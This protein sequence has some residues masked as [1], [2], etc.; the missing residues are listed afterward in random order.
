MEY[1]GDESLPAPT[2]S[3]VSLAREE[4]VGL[5]AVVI[6]NVRLMLENH[7]VHG[8]LS[9]YNILYWAG[10]MAIIDFPQVVDARVNPNAHVLLRRDVQR[11]CD[12]FARYQVRSDP[13]RIVRE[14]WE[15]Y[16]GSA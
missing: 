16:M 8:D 10:K 6:D 5:F 2:L 9:A 7:F 12:Y 3:D 14:L 13:T 11:V 1:I 15:P 4:A